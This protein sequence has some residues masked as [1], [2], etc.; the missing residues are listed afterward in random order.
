MEQ[1]PDATDEEVGRLRREVARLESKLGRGAPD[2]VP[3]ATNS[4]SRGGQARVWRPVVA[5]VL[6]AV[7][8]LLA[9]LSV[10][11]IW[12]HDQI[13]DTDRYVRT[14]E[15]LG[16]DPA[17][18]KAV[19]ERITKEIFDRLDVKGVT[20]DAVDALASR[21]L[22]PVA[23]T[24]LGALS[25]PL[26]SAIRTFIEEQV[27][28]LVHSQQFE[29]AWVDAN[30]EAHTQMVAVLT[31]KTSDTVDVEG[32]TVSVNLATVIDAVKQRLVD[33]GF[34]LAD[35]IPAVNAQFV[36]LESADLARAQ[37]AVRVLSAVANGLP[38]VALALLGV[39]IAV[40]RSH[41]RALVAGALAVAASMLLLGLGLNAFRIVYLDA[42][43]PEKLSPA[44]AAAVYDALT[45]FI[46]LNLRAVLVL[47][48]AI[49]A[50]AWVSGP[51]TAP[52][53]VRRG[54]NHALDSVRHGSDRAGLDT[55]RLGVAL[56]A[57]RTPLRAV[58]LGVA[59][60]V[61]VMAAHP[62]GTFT[63]VVL[64]VAL[65]VLVVMELLARPGG[66]SPET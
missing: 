50:I 7:A 11:A 28:R 15:P 1:P 46:R 29:D 6:I 10:V 8:A 41:R 27:G 26:A 34:S 44:A 32:G 20:Q 40:A 59:L 16:S 14:V 48:L 66:R 33:R 58:V 53:A 30:R 49:A 37:T 60:L 19:V 2:D 62:T 54:A 23:A 51:G 63:L 55:G 57:Y 5:G 4:A 25:T 52:T 12:A 22:P 17:V 43:P 42:V 31:G 3:A 18:Q 38:W 56:D 39:A 47:F 13:G 61:Y 36:I 64:G 21:G 45:H 24:S 65:L 9:P 35:R